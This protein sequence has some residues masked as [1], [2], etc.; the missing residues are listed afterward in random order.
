M[1]AL[2]NRTVLVTGASTGIGRACVME[3]ARQGARVFAGVRDAEVGSVLASQAPDR[4]TP[5]L[6]DVTDRAQIAAAVT[7]IGAATRDDGLFGLVNNA[8]IVVAGPLEV[9]PEAALREQFEV[10]TFGAF[11]LT[12]ACLPLLRRARGRIVNV[13]SVNGRI[14]SP[15]T[16][17]YAA[18]K[19]AL[20]AMSDA[21]RRELAPTGV[22]VIVV[23]PGSIRTPIWT[24]SRVRAQRLAEHLP[25]A[26][27]AL[28]TSVLARIG[29]VAVP[30][31]ALPPESVAVVVA[32]ALLA[33]RARTRYRVG[34]DARLGVLL[35][36]ALPGRALDWLMGVRRRRRHGNG[37]GVGRDS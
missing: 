36:H 3:L 30:K 10:N 7:A 29:E 25:P 4:I 28:Y 27:R 5:L 18:S 17:A 11:A 37:A 15:F 9:L 8:G 1:P 22:A 34:W 14:V 20:E 35:A 24:R 12:Q 2:L 33:A 32:K 6:L 19:F 23:Q 31:R 21:L 13:T 26:S 16:G